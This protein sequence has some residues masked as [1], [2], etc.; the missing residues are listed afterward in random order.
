VRTSLATARQDAS[1]GLRPPLIVDLDGT[2]VRSDTLIECVLL[3]LRHPLLLWRALLA[4]RHGKARAKREFAAAAR[5]DAAVLPYDPEIV[6]YLHEQQAAGRVLVLATGADRAI[7]EAVAQ[8]LDL[9]DIVLA[10]DGQTSLTGRAKLDAIRT[11]VGGGRFTYIG[12][13]RADLAVWCEAESGICVN[14][15]RGVARAAAK[16]TAIEHSFAA[17]P[18]WMVP[19]LQAIRPHQWSKNLLVFVPLVAARAIGDFAG[20]ADAIAIFVA[21]CCTASGVYLVNDLADLAADRR[22]PSKSRRPL[23]SGALPLPVG[24]IAGPL[25]MLTGFALAAAAGSLPMLLIYAAVSCAYSLWLKSMPLVDVFVLAALYGMRLLAGGFA[26]GYHVSLWLLAF[27]SF[28]FLGLAIVKRVAELMALHAGDQDGAPGRGYRRA[29][30]P[31]LQL[32]GVASGFVASLVL[33]LY[34]QN[35]LTLPGNHEPS[36]SWIIVPLVLFWECRVWLATARGEMADDP[37]VFAARDWMSWLVAA[38]CFGVLL[39]DQVARP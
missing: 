4:L 23:A 13:S 35:E 29:D 39:I 11:A 3:L 30:L 17:R 16:A 26:T 25:L 6:A 31:V 36:W 10:S 2:L 21:F 8:H 12:N 32:M 27:S 7:A 34:V 9:F 33:A 15:R 38:A 18:G 1:A 14:A 20:W 37:I 5:L 19:L 22:H 24:M 28:L